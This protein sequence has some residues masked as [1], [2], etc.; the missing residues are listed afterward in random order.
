MGSPNPRLVNADFENLPEDVRRSHSFQKEIL[1]QSETA[2]EAEL[3]VKEVEFIRQ[4]RSNDPAIGYN[5]WPKF[6]GQE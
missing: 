1:W 5:R 6:K 4:Y 3:A 2:S